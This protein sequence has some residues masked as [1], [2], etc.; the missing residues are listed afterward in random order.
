[1]LP[2]TITLPIQWGDMDSLGH[3]NNAKYFT[4]FESAR[5]ALFE[6]VG[7][8]TS[9]SPSEGPILARTECDFVA[10]LH[11]PGEILVGTGISRVGTKSFTMLYEIARTDAPDDLVAR[12][13]GVIVMMDYEAGQTVEISGRLRKRLEDLRV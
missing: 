4:W 9:G 8:A 7:M 2:V 3:V 5:M 13:E 1:M 11:W 6:R 12:G 10:P